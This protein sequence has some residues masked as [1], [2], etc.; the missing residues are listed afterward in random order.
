V[1]DLRKLRDNGNNLE[2]LEYHH[3]GE[4]TIQESLH[5][6]LQLQK[7]FEWQLQQTEGLFSEQRRKALAELQ[8]RLHRLVE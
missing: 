2:G 4:M 5:H 6:W 8:A 7:A 1:Q 3:L